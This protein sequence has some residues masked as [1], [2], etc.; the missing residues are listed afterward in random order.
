MKVAD[1]SIHGRRH[2]HRHQR[3]YG[4]GNKNK[5]VEEDVVYN[6]ED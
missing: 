5:E 3:L 2:H 4:D 1:E 6:M